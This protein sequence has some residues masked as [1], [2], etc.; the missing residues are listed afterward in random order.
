VPIATVFNQFKNANPKPKFVVTDGGGIDLMNNNCTAGDVNC[1]M[2]QNLKKTMTD[3]IAEMAKSGVVSFIWM[4][5]PDPQ[6]ANWAKLKTGQDIWAVAAKQVM[7]ATTKPRPYWVDLRP[8]W[9]GHY[10]QYT[11]DG[12]HATNA[13]GTATAQAFWDAMKANDY[14]FFKS[15]SV[16]GTND[17]SRTTAKQSAIGSLTARN[18]SLAM[19][20][21]VDKSSEV[22]VRLMTVSGRCVFTASRNV[23]AGKAQSVEFA[24]NGLARG[25]YCS[26]IVTGTS[27]S[28]QPVMVQ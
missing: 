8:V 11:S 21:S 24:L 28:R 2:I 9:A 15:T 1:S 19:S 12:I 10:S 25:V 23:A 4:C 7:D 27:V 26:E 20:L 5:Y 6:G 22:S 13:G 16:Q 3:Y 18:G 17:L 14:A